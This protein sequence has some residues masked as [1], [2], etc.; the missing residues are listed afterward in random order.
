MGVGRQAAGRQPRRR[1][2]RQRVHPQGAPRGLHGAGGTYRNGD[3]EVR[4]AHQ[5][6]RLLRQHRRG[7]LGR[8]VGRT[9]TTKQRKRTEAQ[10]WT[11]PARSDTMQA[12]EQA[13]RAGRRPPAHHQRPT[14]PGAD[15]GA[16]P[17]AAGARPVSPRCAR[18]SRATGA[19]CSP[20]GGCCSTSSAWSDVARKVVGVGSVG[21]RAWIIL[22]L[23]R[24]EGDP[25][26]LQAKEASPRCWRPTPA[27]APTPTRAAGWS[28]ASS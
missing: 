26:F 14:A 9:V 25:L 28:R 8:A 10:T 6:G 2:P 15:R 12:L 23:G 5:P 11:R 24:D 18:S 7:R 3:A 22:L 16:L 20:T 21:T 17:R 19:R 4:R 1:R 27:P 13:D